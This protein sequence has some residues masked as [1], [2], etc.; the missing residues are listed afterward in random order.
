MFGGGLRL[1]PP[2]GLVYAVRVA[3]A[4]RSTA[5]A[6]SASIDAAARTSHDSMGQ[7]QGGPLR[8]PEVFKPKAAPRQPTARRVYEF[9]A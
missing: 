9:T 1:V 4:H 3:G 8:I 6:S 7:T 5:K 2:D